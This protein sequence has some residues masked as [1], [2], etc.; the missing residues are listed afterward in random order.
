M[1]N[2]IEH[3]FSD[4]RIIKDVLWW[5]NVNELIPSPYETMVLKIK[6]VRHMCV[7]YV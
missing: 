4:S 3:A 7:W 5:G 2:P 1:A 6:E